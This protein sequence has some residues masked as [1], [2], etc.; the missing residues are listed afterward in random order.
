[1]AQY[2]H[3]ARGLGRRLREASRHRLSEQRSRFVGLDARLRLLS[4]DNVL[5][6]GYSITRDS[7]N[8]QVIRDAQA[9]SAGQSLRTRLN[10]GEVI[11]TVEKVS[12]AAG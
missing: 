4:P 2:Q 11:S 10:R 12:G 9:L 5:A 7:V 6:R 3:D 1:L 8:G